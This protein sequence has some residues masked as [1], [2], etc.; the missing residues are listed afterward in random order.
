MITQLI[1][2]ASTQRKDRQAL[3]VAK[4]EICTTTRLSH[5]LP[6]RDD[7]GSF[8]LPEH[9]GGTKNIR[10]PGVAEASRSSSSP[11]LPRGFPICHAL[12]YVEPSVLTRRVPVPTRRAPM[13]TCLTRKPPRG[14]VD[15]GMAVSQMSWV[16]GRL[17][18]RTCSRKRGRFCLKASTPVGPHLCYRG[19]RERESGQQ[20]VSP[21]QRC[22]AAEGWRLGSLVVLPLFLFWSWSLLSLRGRKVI[23]RLGS[24][25]RK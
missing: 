12:L 24:L 10:P 14:S 20:D 8:I 11:F 21:H 19:G 22:Q 16:S 2:T 6:A 17:A 9:G 5:P 25:S 1:V 13:S 7:S 23:A 4:Q 18:R 3:A 15:T